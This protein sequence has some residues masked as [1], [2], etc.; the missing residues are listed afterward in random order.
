MKAR[1]AATAVSMT[2]F[3]RSPAAVLRGANHRLVAML[4]RNRVAFYVLEPL[5]FEAMMDALADQKFYCRAAKAAQDGPVAVTDQ[6]RPANVLLNMPAAADIEFK[7]PKAEFELKP[8]D[9]S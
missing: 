7:P 6:G 1:L 4:K 5:L 8:A 3:K 2:E 9:F